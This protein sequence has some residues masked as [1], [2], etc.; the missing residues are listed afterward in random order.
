LLEIGNN[1]VLSEG[2][3]LEKLACR[4]E[5][6]I[7]REMLEEDEKGREDKLPEAKKV[8]GKGYEVIE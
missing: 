1:I 7:F 3:V 5:P 8:Q 2:K 4:V 6:T